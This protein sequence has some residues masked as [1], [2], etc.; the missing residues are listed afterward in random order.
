MKTCSKCKE[1]KSLKEFYKADNQKHGRQAYCK[2]CVKEYN[3]ENKDHLTEY[4]RKYEQKN[5]KRISKRKS[6]YYQK[7]RDK[8]DRRNKKW[9]QKN[10]DKRAVIK[11]RYNDANKDKIREYT[12][13][14]KDKMAKYYQNNKEHFKK[15]GLIWREKNPYTAQAM[16]LSNAAKNRAKKK[17]ISIDLDFFST[18]NIV[19]WLKRQ[20][21]C[22]CCNVKF[23]IGFKSNRKDWKKSYSNSPSIDRL[24]P[25]LGYVPDN[26]SL[27][28][29]R[30]NSHKSDAT[31]E[32]IKRMYFWLKRKLEKID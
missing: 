17:N 27:I 6:G 15:L 32:E 25:S 28:C 29:F 26:V 20:P 7:N 12:K 31:L 4:H 3:Q 23:K 1:N 8:I 16:G 2:N 11:K 21:R 5:K 13:K 24:V 22:E 18:P 10:R 19:D 30:C 14:N 9:D